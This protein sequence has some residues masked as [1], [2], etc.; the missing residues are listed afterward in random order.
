VAANPEAR[1]PV[2]VSDGTSRNF[3]RPDLEPAG[4]QVRNHHSERH[5]LESSNILAKDPSRSDLRNKPQHLRPEPSVA[6]LASI[7]PAR[8]TGKRLARKPAADEIDESDMRPPQVADV[9]MDRHP[10]PMLGQDPPT[11]GVDFAEGHGP[12]ASGSLQ[13][14]GKSS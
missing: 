1:P 7:S 13:A 3:K 4:F 6:R 5:P 10:R 11:P 9:A 2:I 8:G 14:K 12:K